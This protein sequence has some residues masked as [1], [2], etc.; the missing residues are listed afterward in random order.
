MK[1]QTGAK[2]VSGIAAA[3]TA[4]MFIGFAQNNDV[5]NQGNTVEVV[6]QA[7]SSSTDQALLLEEEET[8][9]SDNSTYEEEE[10]QGMQPSDRRTG[11]S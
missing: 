6:E 2:W 7:E 10:Y 9:S 8:V 5:E 3:L 11:R 1:K 4:A